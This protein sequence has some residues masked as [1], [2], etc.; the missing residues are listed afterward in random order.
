[1]SWSWVIRMLIILIVILVVVAGTVVALRLTDPGAGEAAEGTPTAKESM[2]SLPPTP[3]P[4]VAPFPTLGTP[5]PT[6][7]PVPPPAPTP[8]PEGTPATAIAVGDPCT[9]ELSAAIFAANESQSALM[10]GELDA[11]QLSAT[12]GAMAARAQASAASLLAKST[13]AYSV[14]R[15]TAI[16]SQVSNCTVQS[17]SADESEVVVETQE[18][19]TYDAVLSCTASDVEQTSRE[20][21]T[22]PGQEYTFAREGDG[23]RMQDWSLGVVNIDPAWQC[24]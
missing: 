12:W 20:V 2:E 24:T 18:V 1:M 8:V 16:V 11:A 17:V 10:L 9:P 7:I 5:T 6:P 13:D 21:V 23:W 14:D 3:T 22:Y 19:W 4:S 15:I